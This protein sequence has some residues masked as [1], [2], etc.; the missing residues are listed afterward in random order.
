MFFPLAF[1]FFSFVES[2]MGTYGY[3]VLFGLLLCCGMGLP[4]PEDI[5]LFFAGLF[6]AQGKMNLAI[7]AITAWF[8]IIG[9]D[10]ILYGLGM[11]FGTAITKVPII[12]HHIDETRL[13][14]T[15]EK[16]EQYG[17]WVVAIGRMVAG[18][19]GVMVLTAGTIRFNIV[20][21]LI[22]DGLAAIVSGGLFLGL[23][24]YCGIKMGDPH[25]LERKIEHYK[26]LV[27]ICVFGAVSLWLGWVWWQNRRRGKRKAAA[28][29]KAVIQEAV[30]R[31]VE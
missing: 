27:S 17:I 2:K 14:W 25:Q 9:G 30:S 11:R 10:C 13:K 18:I 28:I 20:K 16:F 31:G 22:A 5:P 29:A 26:T 21:F 7:A 8:G 12:G 19:R 15:H 24:Y 1:S 6:A 23:G 3:P 4:L